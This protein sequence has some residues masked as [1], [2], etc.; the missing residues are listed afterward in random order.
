MVAVSE[1]VPTETAHRQLG[2]SPLAPHQ[3][4]LV[5]L[6]AAIALHSEVAVA[7]AASVVHA[8]AVP[9]IVMVEVASVVADNTHERVN[10]NIGIIGELYRN[11]GIREL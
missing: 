10:F 8:V 2:T 6:A 3:A 4:I 7:G 5:A 1:A 9:A 11:Q